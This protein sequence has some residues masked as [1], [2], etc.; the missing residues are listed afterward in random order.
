MACSLWCIVSAGELSVPL[1]GAD[2][3]NANTGL[4][5]IS[6]PDRASCIDGSTRD[7]SIDSHPDRSVNRSGELLSI[8]SYWCTSMGHDGAFITC[9]GFRRHERGGDEPYTFMSVDPVRNQIESPVCGLCGKG[10][11]KRKERSMS[12]HS[13]RRRSPYQDLEQQAHLAHPPELK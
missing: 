9:I 4:T 10:P 3:T 2:L 6:A 7:V 1:I 8:Y 5:F 12:R 13:Q 11:Q